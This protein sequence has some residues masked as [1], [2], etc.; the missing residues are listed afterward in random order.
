[1]IG[2][3]FDDS[4]IKNELNSDFSTNCYSTVDLQSDFSLDNVEIYPEMPNNDSYGALFLMDSADLLDVREEVIGEEH[5]ASNLDQ[6]PYI[7]GLPKKFGLFSTKSSRISTSHKDKGNKELDVFHDK[8]SFS[9]EQKHNKCPWNDGSEEI[10]DKAYLCNPDS[11]LSISNDIGVTSSD[12][13]DEVFDKDHVTSHDIIDGDDVSLERLSDLHIPLPLFHTESNYSDSSQINPSDSEVDACGLFSSDNCAT[14]QSDD[15][16]QIKH[17]TSPDSSNSNSN[18]STTKIPTIVPVSSLSSA[19]KTELI[20]LPSHANHLT[21]TVNPSYPSRPIS[22]CLSLKSKYRRCGQI[23][24]KSGAS[25]LRTKSSFNELKPCFKPT[26]TSTRIAHCGFLAAPRFPGS[27]KESAVSPTWFP[28]VAFVNSNTPLT[29][30]KPA[31]VIASSYPNSRSDATYLKSEGINF[32]THSSVM[33][34]TDL[35]SSLLY[36]QNGFYISTMRHNSLGGNNPGDLASLVTATIPSDFTSNRTVFCPHLGCGKTFR[37][38]AAMRK[39]LHTH[40]PRVHIC[41]ECGKAFVESSKLKRHQ[42]VHTGEKPYQCAFD[43]CG[44]RFSLDFNLRTHLRIHTGDRPYP[45]PQPGCSKR[46]AQSTNLKSHLATHSKIRATHQSSFMNRHHLNSTVN[47]GGVGSVLLRPAAAAHPNHTHDQHIPN[48][49]NGSILQSPMNFSTIIPIGSKDIN[50]RNRCV[51]RFK[52]N[53]SSLFQEVHLENS[54]L[55]T[56]SL[57]NIN[58][59][60]SIP[61]SSPDQCEPTDISPLSPLDLT[62]SSTESN[63]S[64]L[65][66]QS[67]TN[68]IK[69]NISSSSSVISKTQQLFTNAIESQLNEFTNPTTTSDAVQ[70]FENHSLESSINLDHEKIDLSIGVTQPMINKT[71]EDFSN[72]SHVNIDDIYYQPSFI[73]PESDIIINSSIPPMQNCKTSTRRSRKCLSIT[74]RS[75]SPNFEDFLKTQDDISFTEDDP[76]SKH[77]F[78]L[79]N[80]NDHLSSNNKTTTLKSPYR[81]RRRRHCKS[82]SDSNKYICKTSSHSNNNMLITSSHYGT[83]SKSRESFDKLLPNNQRGRRRCTLKTCAK[84]RFRP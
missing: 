13:I 75:E 8:N 58:N 11:P 40:G 17:L 70:L 2:S 5:L 46:F 30:R 54:R 74:K 73:K 62:S 59:T 15:Y 44:K 47:S 16:V 12:N 25:I 20:R 83:R 14:N 7:E 65:S 68:H 10:T 23:T 49:L 22:T 48:S 64:T 81:R 27:M 57:L 55:H 37:D 1:M 36:S 19:E 24:L 69:Y 31:I 9:D 80:G 4:S 71:D 67:A 76:L 63:S 78:Y 52:S 84:R 39:H 3:F 18:E 53:L 61:T 34:S 21:T 41:A 35:Q 38:T 45:C 79:D 26:F 50:V 6:P 32:M 60:L 33:Q 82:K 77:H 51:N 42:L 28:K 66:S 72:N 29:L 56:S 43:G